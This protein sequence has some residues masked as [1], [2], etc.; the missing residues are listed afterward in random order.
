MPRQPLPL[1]PYRQHVERWRSCTRCVF[2]ENRCLV[3]IARGKV[4]C[5]ICF[6]GEGPG[7][8]EDISG[9][10]F[11]GEAGRRLDRIVADAVPPDLRVCLTNLTCCVPKYPENPTV[12]DPDGPGPEEIAACAPRLIEFLR[13]AK[14]RLIVKVGKHANT[15]LTPGYHHSILKHCEDLKRIPQVH[16]VHPAAILRGSIAQR[17]LSF[18]RCMVQ[19]RS[20]VDKYLLRGEKVEEPAPEPSFREEYDRAEFDKGLRD[21]GIPF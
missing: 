9:K 12:K 16:I 4:P 5:D 10:P 1:S 13:L 20:A 2:H 8:A 17:G 14:P 15:Y 11:V 21:E 18:H 7:D 6:I 19:V 3:V